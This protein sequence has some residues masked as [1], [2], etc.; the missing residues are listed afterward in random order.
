[1]RWKP[2]ASRVACLPLLVST[3]AGCAATSL[4]T[5]Q[6]E[7]ARIP[8]PPVRLEQRDLVT[9]LPTAQSFSKKVEEHLQNVQSLPTSDPSN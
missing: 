2:S 8:S 5:P 6:V 3:L 4:P 1:M 9:Y 7:Q